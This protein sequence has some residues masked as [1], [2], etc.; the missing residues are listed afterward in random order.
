MHPGIVRGDVIPL[1]LGQGEEL[2][3]APAVM[4]VFSLIF[5]SHCFGCSH[6]VYR[7]PDGY[8][9]LHITVERERI[10]GYAEGIGKISVMMGEEPPLKPLIDIP[11]M[12]EKATQ[13]LRN[14]MDSLASRGA[15]GIIAVVHKLV[16]VVLFRITSQP[17]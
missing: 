10:G 7:Q 9:L 2:F 17:A 8:A 1:P 4:S 3:A 16:K 6:L 11:R 12:A 5:C 15:A 14:S 13:M